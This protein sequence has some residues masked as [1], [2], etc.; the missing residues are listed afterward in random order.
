MTIM[1][2]THLQA[3]GGNPDHTGTL[4]TALIAKGLGTLG[5]WTA[6]EGVYKVSWPRTDVPV[7]VDGVTLPPFMGLTTWV[8]FQQSDD[9]AMVMGDLVLFQDE[10]NPV[11]SVL[12]DGGVAVTALHNHFFYSDP[13]VFFM[14][15]GGDGKLD[16]FVKTV[17]AT[18]DKIKTIRSEHSTPATGFGSSGDIGTSSIT[19]APL[20]QIL[21][22]KGSVKNGM[23]KF[24]FG[25]S[26]KMAC[27]CTARE[28]DGN[29]HLGGVYGQR[30]A[31]Y[32]RR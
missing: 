30:F 3:Q 13:P 20:E 29:Q 8:G 27:G 14:H 10:V 19:V 25:R 9:S 23:A 17:R 31:C 21:G 18:L 4:D 24:V 16:G 11:M 7:K 2:V 32:H 12:L 26:V 1:S 28:R 15:I 22:A 6:D 5:V